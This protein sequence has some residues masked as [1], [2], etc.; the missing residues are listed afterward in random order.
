MEYIVYNLVDDG[1]RIVCVRIIDKDSDLGKRI[2]KK[3]VEYKR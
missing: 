1:D 3:K 2:K